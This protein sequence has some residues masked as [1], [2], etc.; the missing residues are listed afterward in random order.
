MTD[1]VKA[2]LKPVNG[3]AEDW[4][5]GDK[6][7]FYPDDSAPGVGFHTNEIASGIVP[8]PG[9]ISGTG[10]QYLLKPSQNN[11]F[12]ALNRF[13]KK[14]GQ[15]SFE[16]TSG[17]YLVQGIS[18]SEMENGSQRFCDSDSSDQ[19]PVREMR[20]QS[21]IGL[22]QP[23]PPSMDEGWTRWV[24]EQY[25][26]GFKNIRPDEIGNGNLKRDYDVIILPSEWVSR[27][28]NGYEKGTI[29]PEYEGGLGSAEQNK[30]DEFCAKWRNTGLSESK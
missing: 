7:D 28:E 8:K 13:L 16:K 26:F 18:N 22:Y 11:T 4:K 29:H 3:K 9:V 10:N 2:Q 12:K 14:G 23:W 15:I 5:K 6:E 17:Q 21:R 19:R 24:M 25:G 30:L 20:S 27:L 1:E